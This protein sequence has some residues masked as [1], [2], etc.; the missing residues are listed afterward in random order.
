[1]AWE[2]NTS[3]TI[4]NWIKWHASTASCKLAVFW[5]SIC[6]FWASCDSRHRIFWWR[7][8]FWPT[9]LLFS[10]LKVSLWHRHESCW[11]GGLNQGNS[12]VYLCEH[13]ICQG[14]IET[15]DASHGCF[16]RLR[17]WCQSYLDCAAKLIAGSC[18]LSSSLAPGTLLRSFSAFACAYHEEMMV[19]L[20]LR[21]LAW[22]F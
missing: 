11:I 5:V 13:Q 17:S 16:Q 12:L 10:K 4:S 14:L 21:P 20:I 22:S 1:M 18:F 6:S 7:A 2:C 9:R 19:S 8:S 3:R 15:T